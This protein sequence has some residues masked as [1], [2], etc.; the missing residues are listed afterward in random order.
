MYGSCV[1]IV[2]YNAFGVDTLKLD[3][4]KLIGFLQGKIPL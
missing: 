3:K 4:Q 2:E 1:Q